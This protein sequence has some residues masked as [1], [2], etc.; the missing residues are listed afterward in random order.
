MAQDAPGNKS[1]RGSMTT[2]VFVFWVILIV[3]TNDLLRGGRFSLQIQKHVPFAK[4]LLAKLHP[5][6]T[7]AYLQ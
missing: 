4:I 5:Y 7:A 1:V 6:L 3:F 2:V